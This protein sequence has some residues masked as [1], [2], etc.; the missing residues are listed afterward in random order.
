MNRFFTSQGLADAYCHPK[1]V[2]ERFLAEVDAWLT[3][4]YAVMPWR[5]LSPEV[6]PRTSYPAAKTADEQED[7]VTVAEAQRRSLDGKMSR[8]WWYRTAQT[9]R[10]PT[11]GSARRF[12]SAPRTSRSSS[13]SH[14]GRRRSRGQTPSQ[15]PPRR[16]RLRRG[17]RPGRSRTSR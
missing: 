4:R 5:W 16:S 8:K 2:L 6:E 12:C 3:G 11:I 17:V 15:L 1:H 10:L 14:G 13:P 7:F 9:G